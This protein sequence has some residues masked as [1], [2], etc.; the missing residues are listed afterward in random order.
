MPVSS[1][2]PFPLSCN[3]PNAGS[4]RHPFGL[5]VNSNGRY[6]SI[7]F[8]TPNGAVLAFVYL[9]KELSQRLIPPSEEAL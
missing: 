5:E 9:R 4:L 3:P 6:E 7:P 1:F 8:L 2:H